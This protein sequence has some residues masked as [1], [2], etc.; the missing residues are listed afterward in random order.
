MTNGKWNRVW[1]L[2]FS[3]S[4]FIITTSCARN[5]KYQYTNM[6]KQYCRDTDGVLRREITTR[7]IYTN[8]FRGKY[9]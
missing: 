5:T 1:D 4:S 3:I 8:D 9:F 6:L 2:E 7:S